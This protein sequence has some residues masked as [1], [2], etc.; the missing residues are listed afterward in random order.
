[1][2][3]SP[4][5]VFHSKLKIRHISDGDVF[6]S[7]FFPGVTSQLCVNFMIRMW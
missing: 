7:V 4:D 3:H 6:F 1:M 2:K 5:E